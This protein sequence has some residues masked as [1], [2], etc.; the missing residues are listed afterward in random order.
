MKTP[1]PLRTLA[2]SLMTLLIGCALIAP[3]AA[4]AAGSPI[5]LYV[6]LPLTGYAAFFGVPQVQALRGIEAYV[7]KTGGIQG[8]PVKF[9]VKDDQTN[10]QLDVQ[11]ANEVMQTK[12]PVL[13]GPDTTGQCNAVTPLAA[14]GPVTFCFTNGTHPAPGGYVF[15]TGAESQFMAETL[16]HYFNERGLKRIAIITTTDASGQD[17]DRMLQ[18]EAAREN[19]LQIVDRQFF[20]PTDVSANAQLSHIKASNPQAIV[21]W[22]TGTP[23]GTALRAIKDLAI[24]VP[25]ITSPANLLYGEL[26]QYEAL[27]PQELLFPSQSYIAPELATDRAV[28]DQIA[29]MTTE[30]AALGAKPDQGHNSNWDGVMVVISGLRKLGI[31]TTAEK[32]R[33]Y[34]ANQR[35]WAGVNG[36]YDFKS[37]PQRGLDKNSIVI[38]RY[39]PAKVK[40]TGVSRPGGAL[41]R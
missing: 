16:F 26:K 6:L 19:T 36:R 13:L 9:V 33:D 14:K 24:D 10:P 30:L 1:M 32:L 37:Y 35:D 7:N 22:V 8:R 23:F 2:R 12:L 3:G 39:D 28:K 41:I 38:V 20:N 29:I 21:V 18:M 25:I 4:S 11:L 15:G 5:E 17:G 34:I 27:M 40:F 31:G